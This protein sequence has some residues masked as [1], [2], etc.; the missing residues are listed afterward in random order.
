MLGNRPVICDTSCEIYPEIQHLVDDTFWEFD[1]P[2][3]NSITIFAR[4]T[5]NRHYD[6]IKELASSGFFLPVLAN[7]SE[8]SVVLKFQCQ[9]LGL[10]DLVAQKKL[11]LV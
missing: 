4:Q 7:P 8:G 10:L 9:R 2:R 3:E 5:V 6:K 1:Q 11:L